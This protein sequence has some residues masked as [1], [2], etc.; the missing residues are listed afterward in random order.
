MQNIGDGG[1]IIRPSGNGKVCERLGDVRSNWGL[2]APYEDRYK[3]TATITN[4]TGVE[5]MTIHSF[6][7]E[8]G[9]LVNKIMYDD[10]PP[11]CFLVERELVVIPDS[12]YYIVKHERS[13]KC[14]TSYGSEVGILFWLDCGNVGQHWSFIQT[15]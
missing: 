2:T 12:G 5:L 4:F 11:F 14:L 13:N 15:E 9:H 10:Y 6:I 1:G 8:E 3:R 7:R